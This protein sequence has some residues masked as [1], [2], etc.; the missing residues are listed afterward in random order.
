MAAP[1]ALA[2]VQWLLRTGEQVPGWVDRAP[3][4]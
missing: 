4:G 1:D 2:A 3:D